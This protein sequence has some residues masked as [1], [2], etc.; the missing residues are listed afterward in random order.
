VGTRNPTQF[1]CMSRKCLPL[2]SV[3]SVTLTLTPSASMFGTFHVTAF[4]FTHYL[5]AYHYNQSLCHLLSV[6][7]VRQEMEG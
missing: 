3:P 1:L 2:T 4:N 7:G 5:G 6:A